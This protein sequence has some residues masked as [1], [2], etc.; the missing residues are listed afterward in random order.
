MVAQQLPERCGPAGTAAAQL[1]EDRGLGD[2]GADDEA[3]RDEHDADEEGDAPAPREELGVGGRPGDREEHQVGQQ[4][5]DRHPELGE[6]AV[7]AAAAARGVLHR[8]QGGPA[9]L[10]PGGHALEQAQHHQQDRRGD[11]DGGVGGQQ[12]DAD[13]GDAHEQQGHDQ[14]ALAADAVTEVPGE[15]PAQRAHH[16]AHADG[17]ERGEQPG[18]GS[19][20]GE[21]ELPEHQARRRG[22]DEEVVPLDGRADEARAQHATHLGGVVVRR[23]VGAGAHRCPSGRSEPRR[24]SDSAGSRSHA[25]RAG[26]QRSGRLVTPLM[27]FDVS[28][29]G[30]PASS[31]GAAPR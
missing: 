2:P 15:D 9:P 6:R 7:P 29:R 14:D 25:R 17:R 10:A 20:G 31:T 3:D 19:E 23:L 22:V 27:K 1:G 26:H 24:S 21:E 16:E 13:G 30:S 18:G 12:P 4:Q 5:P 28:R 8:H 11:P